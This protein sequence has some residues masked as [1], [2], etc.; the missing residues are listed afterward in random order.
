[1]RFYPV[2]EGPW[3]L[4]ARTAGEGGAAFDTR[5]RQLDARRITETGAGSR[6]TS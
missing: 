1:M 3:R 2:G 5:V 4:Q 6:R